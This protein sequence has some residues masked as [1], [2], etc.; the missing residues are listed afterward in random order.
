LV[1]QYI[2][3][4]ATDTDSTYTDQDYLNEF[5]PENFNAGTFTYYFEST[6]KS[7]GGSG[8]TGYTQF[9]N[10]SDTSAVS[11]SDVS[12]A[13][14]TVDETVGVSGDDSYQDNVGANDPTFSY[15]RG[16]TDS[17]WGSARW[18]INIP[19]GS[20]ITAA[21]ASLVCASISWN[22]IRAD[23]YFQDTDNAGQFTSNDDDI[24]DRTRTSEKSTWSE[25]DMTYLAYTNTSSLV[26]PIQEV[27]DRPGWSPENYLALVIDDTDSNYDWQF[28]QYD[29]GPGMY[30]P[31]LYIKYSDY[32]RQRSGD[33]TSNMPSAAKDM[34]TQ[35][36]NNATNTTSA[37]SSWLIIQVSSLQVPEN[38]LFFL[39]IVFFMPYIV[40][41]WARRKERIGFS[42]MTGLRPGRPLARWG[43]T[44]T[45]R[46]LVSDKFFHA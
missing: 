1:H 43:W 36:K 27:I 12:Q 3:T 14:F 20:E 18:S 21:Y 40:K 10:D 33:I 44:S 16:L 38:L 30:P 45:S 9:W 22:D 4:L 34:D 25:D 11:G 31:K 17:Y 29:L 41:W 28:V 15:I 35:L 42:V 13:G 5:N 8:G 26:S 37:S 2:N 32:R 46:R 7:S 6:L 24:S 39:P 19:Q 23:L